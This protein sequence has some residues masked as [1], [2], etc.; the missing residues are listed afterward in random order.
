MTITESSEGLEHGTG[1]EKGSVTSASLAP[2]PAPVTAIRDLVISWLTTVPV[3]ISVLELAVEDIKKAVPDVT[4]ETFGE[5]VDAALSVTDVHEGKVAAITKKLYDFGESED[6]RSRTQPRR[7][8]LGDFYSP[9]CENPLVVKKWGVTCQERLDRIGFEEALGCQ[10]T[11]ILSKEAKPVTTSPM[12]ESLPVGKD[13]SST[14]TSTVGVARPDG[15]TTGFSNVLV[16]DGLASLGLDLPS[17]VDTVGRKDL[18]EGRRIALSL[19]PVIFSGTGDLLPY[20][21]WK[22]RFDL[23]CRSNGLLGDPVTIFYALNRCLSPALVLALNPSPPGLGPVS[24]WVAEIARIFRFLSQ[25]CSGVSDDVARLG[26]E[27]R[28]AVTCQKPNESI[29]DYVVRFSNAAS[30][31]AAYTG[32]SVSEEKLRT[33]FIRG[34]SASWRT[35]ALDILSRGGDFITLTRELSQRERLEKVVLGPRDQTAY[36]SSAGRGRVNVVY[37][38]SA[39]GKQPIPGKSPRFSPSKKVCYSWRDHGKCRFGNKCPFRHDNSSKP[40][41][42]TA[43][44]VDSVSEVES[45]PSNSSEEESLNHLVIPEKASPLPF[46]SFKVPGV[47]LV[48]CLLDSGAYW[49]YVAKSFLLHLGFGNA[50]LDKCG[51]FVSLPNG[52]DEKILGTVQLGGLLFRVM[53]TA[54]RNGAPYLIIGWDT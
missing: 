31:L 53:D 32:K 39:E 16:D 26:A 15:N 12:Y 3:G 52:V 45:G 48:S 25:S 44:T 34:I 51:D 38:P 37:D 47:G 7:V 20:P 54:G 24:G 33:N 35:H 18:S 22:R 41:F 29:A 43:Q 46:V 49:N 42:L 17:S 36:S 23:L 27:Q 13:G 2:T 19:E 6:R 10:V 8:L 14:P 21:V 5:G 4:R 28:F 30:D 9:F 11:P 50:T 1:T 40:Q